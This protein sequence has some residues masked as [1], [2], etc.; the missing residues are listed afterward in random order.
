MWLKLTD[1]DMQKTIAVNM[2]MVISINPHETSGSLLVG[3]GS[4][5]I[6]VAEQWEAVLSR[7]EEM[8]DRYRD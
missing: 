5:T 1:A 2:D 7:T 4:I 6:H 8:L 3:T